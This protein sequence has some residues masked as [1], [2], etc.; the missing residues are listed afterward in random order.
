M[1]VVFAYGIA[2]LSTLALIILWFI[3]VHKELYQKREAVY[4]ALEDLRLHQNGYQEK[5]GSPEELTAKHMLDTSTQ[6][7]EQIR[8]GYNKTIKKPIYL[9]PGI[10]MGFKAIN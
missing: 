9:L 5:L 3:N 10:L 2:S 6:I 4:K 8:M 1:E 7:Y